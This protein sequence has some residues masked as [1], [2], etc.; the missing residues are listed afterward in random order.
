MTRKKNFRRNLHSHSLSRH[1][2]LKVAAAAL[3]A[4]CPIGKRGRV[5]TSLWTEWG[6]CSRL[7]SA[8]ESR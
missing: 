7:S 6:A 5:E 2:F 4:G 3:L 8:A 1:D